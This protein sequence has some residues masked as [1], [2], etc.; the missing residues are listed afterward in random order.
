MYVVSC[1]VACTKGH[2]T[3]NKMA[4]QLHG[5]HHHEQDIYPEG[6]SIEFSGLTSKEVYLGLE[7][8]VS[9]GPPGLASSKNDQLNGQ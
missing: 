9:K 2:G 4:V 5:V 7:V 6:S 3:D 8:S 1:V